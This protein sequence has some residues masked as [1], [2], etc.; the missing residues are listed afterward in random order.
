[1]TKEIYFVDSAENMTWH[2]CNCGNLSE[3]YV[4]CK[5]TYN[6]LTH[7]PEDNYY[8]LSTYMIL[9][10]P[11]CGGI[12][13][14]R[15]TTFRNQAEDDHDYRKYVE[16]V[17]YSPPKQRH[18]AIP[19][20]ITEVVNQAETVAP[21]SPR[22][23]FMLCRGTLEEICREHGIPDSRIT[24]KGKEEY[25]NLKTKLLMLFQDK[26]LP[27]YLQDILPDNLPNVPSDLVEIVEGIKLLGNEGTHGSQVVF[28]DKVS[29]ADVQILLSLVDY[30][31]ER[32][33]V[34]EVRAKEVV[35]KLSELKAKVL[36]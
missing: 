33:Y 12:T 15:Y 17:L 30:V 18:K 27:D 16:E 35:E 26:N 13:I 36:N 29:V 2:R 11:N 28:T 34:D 9:R 25:I 7:D 4:I 3:M 8:S 23:A 6:S 21:I 10:C 19:S 20:A 22:A 5:G 1:M 24:K 32:M 31:L 14:L